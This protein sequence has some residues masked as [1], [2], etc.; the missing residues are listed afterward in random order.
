M[1]LATI[2]GCLLSFGLVFQ[3]MAGGSGIGG[4]I[5]VPSLGIVFGGTIGSMLMN[6]PM[7]QCSSVI[8]V[9]MHTLIF[10]MSTPTDEIERIVEYANLARREGLLALEDKL[11]SV[12]DPFFAKGIQLV[13][14]GFPVET[15]RDIMELEADWQ[16]QRHSAGRKVLESAA[17]TAP[18][19]G[20]VGT[21]IGLVKML[22]NLSNPDDIGAGMSVALLTTLYGAMLANMVLIPLA[23]KL[24]VRAKEEVLLRDLMVEGIIAIQSGEKPQLIKEKLKSFLAPSARA[25]I[26][27]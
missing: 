25:A 9:T 4:F 16:F 21:L 14:D 12:E 1:D 26:E 2:I 13:I 22:A 19:F 11:Q 5:D 18:A 20:M 10:K 23:G 17:A 7:R 15:V 27:D 8:K 3:A 6:F 24:E